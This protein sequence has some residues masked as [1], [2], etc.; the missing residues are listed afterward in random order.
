MNLDI[1]AWKD[2]KD[3]RH[4]SNIDIPEAKTWIV[5]TRG[6][7]NE[8][9]QISIQLYIPAF[10]VRGIQYMPYRSLDTKAWDDALEWLK[11]FE[12]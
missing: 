12:D 2:G 11:K 3:I 1:Q 9:D 6:K 7:V 8:F 5:K 4:R 10:T